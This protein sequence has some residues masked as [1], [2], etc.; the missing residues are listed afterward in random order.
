MTVNARAARESLRQETA[1]QQCHP[2]TP[3]H[4]SSRTSART[5]QPERPWRAQLTYTR[6][7]NGDHGGGGGALRGY[8]HDSRKPTG[9][10]WKGKEYRK[11]TDC[12]NTGR[13][14]AHNDTTRRLRDSATATRQSTTAKSCAHDAAK[15]ES[16]LSLQTAAT[17]RGSAQVRDE[18]R[19]DQACPVGSTPLMTVN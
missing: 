3:P 6:E 12:T 17:G 5:P 13:T 11:E 14:N 8:E 16:L 19:T 18:W 15:H 9:R 10:G 7:C 2:L 1:E 4:D